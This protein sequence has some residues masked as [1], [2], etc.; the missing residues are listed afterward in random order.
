M[1]L[2]FELKVTKCPNFSGHWDGED[3]RYVQTKD[4]NP[5][6]AEKI[7][8]GEEIKLYP[9]RTEDGWEFYIEVKHCNSFQKKE[10]KQFFRNGYLGYKYMIQ[11][12]IDYQACEKPKE[13]T[14]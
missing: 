8:D 9:H 10:L 14:A 7:L 12:I 11:N 2:S 6:T 3:K 13:V 1:L 4:V 5:I